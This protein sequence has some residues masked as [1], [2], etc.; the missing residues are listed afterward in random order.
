[1]II[2]KKFDT[3]GMCIVEIHGD[4]KFLNFPKDQ[5]TISFLLKNP[6]S[7]Y[8]DD[9]PAHI[10]RYSYK[11]SKKLFGIAH[12]SLKKEVFYKNGKIGRDLK[13]SVIEYGPLYTQEAYW[14]Y[15]KLHNLNGPAFIFTYKNGDKFYTYYVDGVDI[16]NHI[17]YGTAEEIQNYILLR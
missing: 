9:G 6:Q 5:R 17:K 13:P 16:T 2:Y 12:G 8:R 15:D 14:N 1:M 7:I 3:L 11:E 4:P 10:E